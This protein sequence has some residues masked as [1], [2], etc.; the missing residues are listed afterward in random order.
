M[1]SLVIVINRCQPAYLGC[2]GNDWLPTA[3]LDR[4]AAESVVFDQHFAEAPQPRLA[5]RSWHT[6]CYPLHRPLAPRGHGLAHGLWEAQV[7]AALVGDE[8]SPTRPSRFGQGWERQF[9]TRQARLE[10]LEQESLLGGT[11]QAAVEWLEEHRDRDR[12][13]LWLELSSLQLPWSPAEFDD[14]A[15]EGAEEAELEP[16]FDPPAG[17][18]GTEIPAEAAERIPATY[19]GLVCGVDQWLGQ[20]IEFLKEKG[21][22]DDLLLIVTSD[23][24]LPLG[25]HGLVGDARP[26]LHE[27]LVHLP[28]L[29]HL[30]GGAEAGRRVQHLTQA[31][32]LLPTLVEAFDLPL[33]GPVDG[34][35][36]LP[37]ARGSTTKI[38]DHACSF[39][40][41]GRPG[42]W[43]E[44]SLRTHQWYLI[45]PITADPP[46]STQ[47][48]IKPEDRWEVNNVLSQHPEAAE[49][50]ELS[51]RRFHTA[52]RTGRLNELPPLRDDV[53]KLVQS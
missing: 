34:K 42:A 3:T 12:W 19:A 27:E 18:V 33:P 32:D 8:R 17:H 13:L 5:R 2:Y 30:P 26:W 38:R 28:L 23:C 31:V 52:A 20:L 7:D 45:L 24:G 10:A 14:E 46:R 22:Y 25:E 39:A 44:W 1:K 35:S 50:L 53:L 15:T 43:E 47:L 21:L 37:L 16:W 41:T 36:L 4:L 40:W 29:M 49:H 9:W 48:Y 11:I 6:G 51:L